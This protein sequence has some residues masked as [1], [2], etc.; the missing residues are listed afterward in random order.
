VTGDE[1]SRV[2]FGAAFPAPILPAG[3]CDAHSHV[4]GPAALFPYSAQRT[5]EP[6]DAPIEAYRAHARSLGLERAVFVQPAVYGHDHSAMVDALQRGAGRFA[7][8]GLL[9]C[10]VP[11]EELARLGAAGLR[12]ARFNYFPRLGPPPEQDAVRSLA[13]R[14]SGFGW[15]ICLHLEMPTLRA[16]A[17][18][19]QSLDCPVVIDHFA[20]LRLGSATFDD[21]L[22]FLV[23]LMALPNLWI[24]LSGADR[25]VH[26]P[27]QLPEAIGIMRELHAA[28]PE[29]CLWGLDWP[30]PNVDWPPNDRN[31]L[32]LLLAAFPDKRARELILVANPDD[33]YFRATGPARV[34]HANERSSFA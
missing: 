26:S 5:Y 29:R 6:A 25:M 30:H 2:K 31:L 28:A 24:K 4:Y 14:L 8:V 19:I 13:S 11:D 9:D 22:K 12:G 33:L 34:A 18:F 1:E 21:E 32:D 23:E 17:D 16:Q 7:G 15:H 10:T 27:A 20:R 3:A